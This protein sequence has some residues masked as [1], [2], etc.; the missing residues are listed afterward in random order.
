MVVGPV[1]V[2]YG[3]LTKLSSVSRQ[4]LLEIFNSLW[5]EGNI[6]YTVTI[7]QA[8]SSHRTQ[9]RGLPQVSVLSPLLYAVYSN[10]I[11]NSFLVDITTLQYVDDVVIYVRSCNLSEGAVQCFTVGHDVLWDVPVMLSIPD[12]GIK[13]V[14]H[15]IEQKLNALVVILCD[16]RSALE[17][18]N[19][20]SSVPS[21]PLIIQILEECASLR[22]R[23]YELEYQWIPSHTMTTILALFMTTVDYKS[24]VQTQTAMENVACS[25]NVVKDLL[26]SVTKDLPSLAIKTFYLNEK[27]VKH[28][29]E[30]QV[31]KVQ[32]ETDTICDLDVYVVEPSQLTIPAGQS[33]NF[34]L[35]YLPKVPSTVD[36]D[37]F[38]IH[39]TN[40]LEKREFRKKPQSTP[41]QD[42]NSRQSSQTES[43]ELDHAISNAGPQVS[44]AIKTIK[45]LCSIK[46]KAVHRIIELRNESDI[47]AHFQFDIDKKQTVFKID[48]T[49]GVI[50]AHKYQYIRINFM[51]T[52]PGTYI[53]QIYCLVHY[54]HPVVIEAV[55]V[56]TTIKEVY[57]K[58]LNTVRY[59]NLQVLD[60]GYKS[61]IS[62]KCHIARHNPPLTLSVTE[63]DLG[64]G[65]IAEEMSVPQMF[66][67]NSHIKTSVLLKWDIGMY[68]TDVAGVFRVS[69]QCATIP[70]YQSTV[71]EAYFEPPS[72]D[73][74]YGIELEG[75]AYWVNIE[76]TR[77]QQQT[78]LPVPIPL[79]LR[80][81]GHSFPARSYGWMPQYQVSPQTV[82]LP[83]CIPPEPVYTTFLIKRFGHLP[84]TFRLF[85][86]NKTLYTVKPLQGLIEGEYQIV[87]VQ[88]HP[89]PPNEGA[90]AEKWLLQFNGSSENEVRYYV[91]QTLVDFQE[92][93]ETVPRFQWRREGGGLEHELGVGVA[94]KI[95][96]CRNIPGYVCAQVLVTFLSYLAYPKMEIGYK[97]TVKFPPTYPGGEQ[98][99]EVPVRNLTRHCIR[100]SYQKYPKCSA[101]KV[102]MCEG[103][104]CSNERAH[105]TWT[106]SPDMCGPHVFN[107]KFEV[108]A[109]QNGSH[110]MSSPVEI[111]VLCHGSC[112]SVDLVALPNSIN[113]GESKWGIT[114][115]QTFKLFNFGKSMVHYTLRLCR[116]SCEIENK[117]GDIV[118]DPWSGTLPSGAHHEVVVSVSPNLEGP[119]NYTVMYENRKTE[120]SEETVTRRPQTRLVRIEYVC[121]FAKLRITD[122]KICGQGILFGKLALWKLMRINERN[123]TLKKPN[124]GCQFAYHIV[125]PP[126]WNRVLL[127]MTLGSRETVNYSLPQYPAGTRTVTVLILVKNLSG[128]VTTWDLQWYKECK[129]QTVVRARSLSLRTRDSVCPHRGLISMGP[130]TGTLEP[131]QEQVLT[132]RVN[133]HL[134]GIH[135]LTY[136]LSLC[137][138]RQMRLSTLLE[139]IKPT[140]LSLVIDVR[141]FTGIYIGDSDPVSEEYT[142]GTVTYHYLS[143]QVS[144][145]IYIGDSD[146]VSENLHSMFQYVWVYNHSSQPLSY[147]VDT[148]PLHALNKVSFNCDVMVCQNPTGIVLP[149]SATP[150]FFKCKP[151][152]FQKYQA[153]IPVQLGEKT[154]SLQLM[155]EGTVNFDTHLLHARQNMPQT[156]RFTHPLKPVVASVDHIVLKPL[157]THTCAKYIFFLE[158]RADVDVYGYLWNTGESMR[159]RIHK[160]HD[161]TITKLA[162]DLLIDACAQR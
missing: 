27:Q 55:G 20:L 16:S 149:W 162:R 106:F 58:G 84:I 69:P 39:D 148:A 8:R 109:M 22:V 88:M 75:R 82:V 89:S 30:Q 108:Y 114:K 1:N 155:C 15:P 123:R 48:K 158:N 24:S 28:V 112:E 32:R 4:T 66:R 83:P 60:D 160:F 102:D 93:K 80:M 19:G 128:V 143:C 145:V 72:P 52:S 41:D 115:R 36:Y 105:H 63:L 94:G 157:L 133:Y 136:V 87:V 150:L 90:H 51:P 131:L 125:T 7:G 135:K 104:L 122:L 127:K 119:H 6:S 151:I 43:D 97:N 73:L 156:R 64:R 35:Q 142:L 21:H 91:G 134:E 99:V 107:V 152:Q 132:L 141:W 25:C 56:C 121:L 49:I 3:M 42:L 45:F 77:R 46:K 62:D 61:Y 154:G 101:L 76:N 113:F 53:K 159:G 11:D 71:F 23:G 38:S 29:V 10:Y 67:V 139:V 126:R 14:T 18:I 86:P 12:S 78:Q 95:I 37:Y 50:E 79:S 110:P 31:Y 140:Q 47:V 40:G 59:P 65:R 44:V 13:R 34:K 124:I 118:L 81:M 92:T 111:M 74:L 9:R 5:E 147:E 85:P 100:Y 98:Q 153:T 161:V 130:A 138:N 26:L 54:Q 57:A 103:I 116:P 96:Q 17:S 146:P 2:S 144:Q 33:S 137:H 117:R 68:R 120:R 129:C 70:P